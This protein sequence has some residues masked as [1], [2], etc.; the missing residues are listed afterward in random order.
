MA[1]GKLEWLFALIDKTSGPAGA[2][3][4]KLEIL[5]KRLKAVDKAAGE[6]KDPRTRDKLLFRRMELELQR[7]NLLMKSSRDATESWITRLN[8]A[9]GVVVMI[10]GALKTVGGLVADVAGTAGRLAFF[11]GKAAVD[12]AS[13]RET[14][15]IALGVL[16]RSEETARRM[17]KWGVDFAAVTPFETREVLNWQK[18]LFVGGFKEAE[19]PVILKAIGDVGA[20]KDFDRGIIQRL[21]E[22][23]SKVKAEGKLTG[24]TMERFA[25]AGVP[26]G[27][28]YERLGQIYGTTVPGVMK[29]REK[30]AI[31]ADA[32]VRAVVD[33]IREELSG[34]KLGL[35]MDKFSETIPGLLST[36]WS[37]PFEF[38]M[39]LDESEG[40]RAFK[41][42]LKN[43]LA[44]IDQNAGSIK[45]RIADAFNHLA[46]GLFGELGGANG[47]AKAEE[48]VMQILDGVDQ[49]IVAG[50]E[51]FAFFK[52]MGEGFLG[53]AFGELRDLFE[54]PLTEEKLA[55]I[56]E[57]GRELGAALGRILDLV[58]GLTKAIGMFGAPHW[59]T[60]DFFGRYFAFGETELRKKKNWIERVVDL[61]PI[62]TVNRA[63][64][65]LQ[66]SPERTDELLAQAR[67]VTA[68]P[69]A[70]SAQALAARS[71]TLH[72]PVSINVDAR[73]A[74]PETASHI[75]EQVKK[76]YEQGLA[77]SLEI[78]ACHE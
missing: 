76:S 65:A 2:I 6:S 23:L 16:T 24:E 34:G 41:S 62:G 42:A 5:E 26:A 56:T 74:T 9:L 35:L 64:T 37:R 75:G 1:G 19:V 63:L 8:H 13:Y 73:G 47:L 32:G 15:L 60:N 40:F 3:E 51:A 31:G 18:Q 21:I 39:D 43:L 27:K 29:L 44:A 49:L 4:R 30:G 61:S 28:V 69:P 72:A 53:A 17:L 54:G 12:A 59:D 68:T 71:T 38:M 7:D 20:L 58:V 78:L 25:A 11:F 45:A 55:R 77:S 70:M 52:G 48:L 66:A 57:A 14:N 36:L 10:G 33:V 67:G 22:G 46:G 50:K